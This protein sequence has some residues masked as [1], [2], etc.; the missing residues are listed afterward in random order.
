MSLSLE[1]LYVHSWLNHYGGALLDLAQTLRAALI[2]IYASVNMNWKQRFLLAQLK[3]RLKTV[4]NF[5]Y[6]YRKL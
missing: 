1:P 3:Q 5:S 4:F 2:T 6:I